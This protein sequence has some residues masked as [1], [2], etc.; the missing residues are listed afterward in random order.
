MAARPSGRYA[1]SEY[2]TI[3]CT[4]SDHSDPGDCESTVCAVPATITSATATSGLR[5]RHS[6]AAGETTAAGSVTASGPSSGL[7]VSTL[8]I[9]TAHRAA[10]SATS[11][12]GKPKR[13]RRHDRAMAWRMS[14]LYSPVRTIGVVRTDD[15]ARAVRTTRFAPAADAAWPEEPGV[16]ERAHQRR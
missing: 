9:A 1:A 3:A 10:A 6:R 8:A 11:G 12:A 7:P 16:C 4:A 15:R 2:I 13:D 5:R 14:P